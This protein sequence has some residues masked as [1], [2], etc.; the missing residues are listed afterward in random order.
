MLILNWRSF[1][2]VFD[3][4]VEQR[5]IAGAGVATAFVMNSV[6][7]AGVILVTARWKRPIRKRTPPSETLKGATVAAL[8]YVRHS[9]GIITVVVRTGVVFFFPSALFTLL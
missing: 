3:R 8:R 5:A 6:S 4:P 9:P 2:R 1:R 7:F